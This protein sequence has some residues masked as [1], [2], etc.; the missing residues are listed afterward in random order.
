MTSRPNADAFAKLVARHVD[1]VYSAALRQVRDPHLA[2]DV[3]QAVFIILARKAGKISP[4][5]LPGWLFKT[6]RYAARNA[7]KME[8]RHKHH[9]RAAGRELAGE[10][11]TEQRH[12]PSEPSWEI[13]A[14]DLDRAIA[15]LPR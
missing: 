5:R 1:F 15:T 2:E 4:D 10:Q 7:V 12:R 13:V 8:Y 9:E 11:I 14:C 3:T 6:T